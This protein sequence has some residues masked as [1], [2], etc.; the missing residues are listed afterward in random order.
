MCVLGAVVVNKLER[1]QRPNQSGKQ[2]G[3]S[4]KTKSKRE[5][6]EPI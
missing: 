6:Y 2:V 1:V 3:E 4:S 5:R